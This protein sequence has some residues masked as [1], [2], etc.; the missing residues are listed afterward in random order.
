MYYVLCTQY[1]LQS[2]PQKVKGQLVRINQ[3]S[4]KNSDISDLSDLSEIF[5]LIWYN[6]FYEHEENV[7]TEQNKKKKGSRIQGKNEKLQGKA[8]SCQKKA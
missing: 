1:Y 5:W 2:Y 6:R 4:Q 7:S 8:G 3:T